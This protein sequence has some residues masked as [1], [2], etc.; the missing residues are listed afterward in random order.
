VTEES[1][2]PGDVQA[3]LRLRIETYEQLEL[4]RLLHREPAK[5]WSAT[6]L[7][8]QLRISP[9]LAEAAA[10]ALQAAGLADR[11]STAPVI[12]YNYYQADPLTNA[13]VD[14]VLELYRDQPLQILKLMSSNAIERVRTAALRTFAD[15][16]VLK[17]DPD[18]G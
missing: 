4:L 16:F 10:Q 18:R 5:H 17:K 3:F 8:E 2:L 1:G 7:G 14:R 15:A 13:T 6:E 9:E 12:H 11:S